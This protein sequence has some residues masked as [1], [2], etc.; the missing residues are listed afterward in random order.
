MKKVWNLAMVLAGVG[1]LGGYMWGVD[2]WAGHFGR[3]SGELSP[4]AISGGLVAALIY[5]LVLGAWIIAGPGGAE[6]QRVERSRRRPTAMVSYLVCRGEAVFS[7]AVLGSF[8]IGAAGIRTAL[9][10]VA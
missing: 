2:R 10:M 9:W 1:F 6:S 7:A 3:M 5:V 8:C 4:V